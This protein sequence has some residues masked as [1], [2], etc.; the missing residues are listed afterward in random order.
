[1][2]D[3]ESQYKAIA[4]KHVSSNIERADYFAGEVTLRVLFS[5]GRAYEYLGV[6]PEIV[7]QMSVDK[8]PGGYFSRVIR[9]QPKTYKC[10]RIDPDAMSDSAKILIE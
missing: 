7:E 4:F 5:G 2:S 1:M 6:G 9:S 10:R 8:S 3:K